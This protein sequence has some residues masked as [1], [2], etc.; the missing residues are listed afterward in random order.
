M[1][2]E[3]KAYAFWPDI[4]SGIVDHKVKDIKTFKK[5]RNRF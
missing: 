5:K 4:M 2:K 3:Q 1:M